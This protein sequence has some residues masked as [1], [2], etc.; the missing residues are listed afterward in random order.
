M[1]TPVMTGEFADFSASTLISILPWS[2]LL[3]LQISAKIITQQP[4]NDINDSSKGV[5]PLLVPPEAIG[6]SQITL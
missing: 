4:A 2:I 5:G 6:K 1:L 3:F